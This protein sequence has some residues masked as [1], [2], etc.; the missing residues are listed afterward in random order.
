VANSGGATPVAS[1]SKI[2]IAENAGV[3]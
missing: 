2:N 1:Y 3:S